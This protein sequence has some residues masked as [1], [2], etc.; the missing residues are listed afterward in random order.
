[1]NYP[2]RQARIRHLYWI[3]Q[4]QRKWSS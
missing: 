4:R 1:V 3:C 2:S